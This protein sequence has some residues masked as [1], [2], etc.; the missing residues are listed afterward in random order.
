MLGEG[1][2]LLF[3]DVE[4]FYR[5]GGGD[6][7]ERGDDRFGLSRMQVD[8]VSRLVWDISRCSG[9]QGSGDCRVFGEGLGKA[10]IAAGLG[11]VQAVAERQELN[12]VVGAD[13]VRVPDLVHP[14]DHLEP[15]RLEARELSLERVESGQPL[16][17]THRPHRPLTQQLHEPTLDTPTDSFQTQNPLFSR[18]SVSTEVGENLRDEGLA[19]RHSGGYA[20]HVVRD[21]D[22]LQ[23]QRPAAGADPQVV[24]DLH[25]VP[26]SLP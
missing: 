10:E 1:D 20:M 14:G 17:T 11:T 16:G 21:R 8:F 9:R 3:G 7:L 26:E 4:V 13:L 18:V 12:G 24:V 2:E 25:R 23:R 15:V 19:I 22:Q 6:L 5:D